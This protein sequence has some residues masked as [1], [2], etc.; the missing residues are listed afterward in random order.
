MTCK[1]CESKGQTEFGS[2]I[3]IHFPGREGLDKPA[4]LVFP[5]LVVCLDCG[6][7]HFTIPET[8][9][10]LLA[11]GTQ[12]SEPSLGQSVGERPRSQDCA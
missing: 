6:F 4:V 7:T 12:T 2:E 10:A 1:S 5:K 11:E 3:N 8:E 9:L